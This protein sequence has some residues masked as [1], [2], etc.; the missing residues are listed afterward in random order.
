ME[1][2]SVHVQQ[3]ATAPARQRDMFLQ[4]YFQALRPDTANGSGPHPGQLCESV[5]Q[6]VQVNRKKISPDLVADDRLNLFPGHVLWRSV[7]TIAATTAANIYLL[8]WKNGQIHC[9]L[10]DEVTRGQHGR[11]DQHVRYE[12]QRLM[13]IPHGQA[14]VSA[15]PD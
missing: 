9:P 6:P 2:L 4:R 1:Q 8:E 15:A 7:T 12:V 13:V 10:A 14:P 5:S 3:R 11:H